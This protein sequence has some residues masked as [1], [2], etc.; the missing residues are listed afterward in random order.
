MFACPLN[1]WPPETPL[2]M[3]DTG[4]VFS[5]GHLFRGQ[6][7]IPNM[8]SYDM[9]RILITGKKYIDSAFYK[10]IYG[11]ALDDFLHHI[12]RALT[13]L[14]TSYGTFH[15]EQFYLSY[16]VYQVAP[17]YFAGEA[18]IANVFAT[19]RNPYWD[20]D[21]IQLAYDIQ[22]STLAFSKRFHTED[23]RAKKL[24]SILIQNNTDLKNGYINDIPIYV[25]ASGNKNLFML[26]R[27]YRHAK[28]M[29]KKP[30]ISI[31]PVKCE[32]WTKWYTNHLI[33]PVD[34]LITED[35]ILTNYIRWDYLK[36]IKQSKN[37]QFIKKIITAEIILNLINNRWIFSE[38]F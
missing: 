3:N 7:N 13:A 15:G 17:K 5:G 18:S 9:S 6:A 23:F 21:I 14:N 19:L 10:A 24:Q 25:Y 29:I 16:L 8:I 11:N 37:I 2:I 26:H 1:R 30:F 32:D 38:N 31:T 20:V 36:K 35:C 12:D 4:V 28:K 27:L 34:E 22:Y 33:E